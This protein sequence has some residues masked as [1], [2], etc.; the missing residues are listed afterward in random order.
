MD[1]KQAITDQIIEIMEGGADEWRKTWR[2]SAAKGLPR[3]GSTGAAYN[4]VNFFV[5]SVVG[6]RCGY[7]TNVWMTYKQAEGMGAQV[8]KGAKG[9]MGIYFQMMQKKKDAAAPATD[10]AET[11]PFMRPFW[12]FNAAQIDGLP[13]SFTVP[14]PAAEFDSIEAADRL[15]QASGA[16]IRHGYT[17]A[18]FDVAQDEVCMPAPESFESPAAYYAVAMHELAHWTGGKARLDR[19]QG[20]SF[21]SDAYAF[22]ELI[23][24]LGSAYLCAQVGIADSTVPNHASYLASWVKVLKADKSAIFTASKQAGQAYDFL[25]EKAG[26]KEV[27]AE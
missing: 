16:Q 19:D 12:V 11:F 2:A 26:L 14:A 15:I 22:E 8:R 17:K 13:E 23:A 20:G 24:E 3:N 5:L 10:K 27:R 25:L 7:P 21:G 9:V 6:A 1:L 4:G 18:Y